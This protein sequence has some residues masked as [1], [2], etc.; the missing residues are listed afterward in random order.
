MYLDNL[1][2]QS[3]I[4]VQPE[5]IRSIFPVRSKSA[6]QVNFTYQVKKQV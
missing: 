2:E 4:F 1:K 3:T 5:I 6:I